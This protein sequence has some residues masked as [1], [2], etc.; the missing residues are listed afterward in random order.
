MIAWIRTLIFA[1]AVVA[2]F[3][4][5]SSAKVE[6]HVPPTITVEGTLDVRV[7][8]IQVSGIPSIPQFPKRIV[9]RVEGLPDGG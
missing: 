5:A 9:V 8:T 2:G 3:H 7:P 4:I 1:A 6:V